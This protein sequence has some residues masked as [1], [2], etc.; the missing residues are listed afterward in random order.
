MS[1]AE[2]AVWAYGAAARVIPFEREPFRS[3]FNAAY[4]AYKRFED[5]FAAL[6][7]ARPE[8]FR[9]GHIIDAGANI[10]YT[11]LLFAR[12]VSNPFVVHAIEPHPGCAEMLRR[13][14]ERSGLRERI[15]VHAAAAGGVAGTAKLR[16][17]RFHPAD[18]RI[19]DEGVEVPLVRVDDLVGGEPVRFVKI[20]V[21]G[22][23]L[24]VS[25]GMRGILDTN[26]TIA[27]AIEYAPSALEEQGVAPQS[28][29]DFYS[30]R[31]FGLWPLI[32]SEL[33]ETTA[34]KIAATI[35]G[36]QYVNLLCLRS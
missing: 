22:Y 27:V 10:G 9:G 17:N 16:V 7:E 8:L 34:A 5:P 26:R 20:D 2:L 15:R 18:H 29:L 12:A 13:N 32:G 35:Q 28:L 3:L 30:E 19:A 11:A 24:E 25:R 4:F 36:E 14:V 6:I 21:Q 31:D 1:L 23:E 33:R